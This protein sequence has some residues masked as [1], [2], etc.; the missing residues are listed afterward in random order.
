LAETDIPVPEPILFVKSETSLKLN[1]K[2]LAKEVSKELSYEGKG[3]F[4][5]IRT[6]KLKQDD[7]TNAA[8]SRMYPATELNLEEF[9]DDEAPLHNE[10]DSS[11]NSPRGKNKIM[12]T[13]D[14]EARS[15]LFIQA[16]IRVNLIDNLI[17]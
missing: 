4:S 1:L 9:G 17:L 12:T 7:A 10:L 6:E 2:F 14:K 5:N 8:I 15:I 13:S 11:S 16:R 3:K